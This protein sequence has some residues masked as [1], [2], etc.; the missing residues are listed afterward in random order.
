[1]HSYFIH[2]R[3]LI[4]IAFLIL[5]GVKNS[6]AQQRDNININPEVLNTV[7]IGKWN[8]VNATPSLQEAPFDFFNAQGP[9]YGLIKKKGATVNV[10]C[11][12][13]ANNSGVVFSDADGER[14]SFKV[15]SLTKNTITLNHEN[16]V[17]FF[18]KEIK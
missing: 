17:L 11:K 5:I 6:T 12:I 18:Q 1:M 13:L 9:G 4:I 2:M 7:L 14:Y 3:Q 8:L 16:L 10:V 15:T